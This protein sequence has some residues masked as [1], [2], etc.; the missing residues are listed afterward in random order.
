MK[1]L[2]M[3]YDSQPAGKSLKQTPLS[4]S[5]GRSN[6]RK[7]RQRVLKSGRPRQIMGSASGN[8]N[9]ATLY[10]LRDKG[11]EGKNAKYKWRQKTSC[12][13]GPR[14]G[15]NSEDDEQASLRG[16]DGKAAGRMG[17]SHCRGGSGHGKGKEQMSLKRFPD[18][19]LKT[20]RKGRGGLAVRR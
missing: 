8:S 6:G 16:K 3:G 19:L 10:K 15:L 5:K 17:I 9:T 13:L 4:R 7:R 14:W 20:I 18:L 1:F 12:L 11:K 2:A